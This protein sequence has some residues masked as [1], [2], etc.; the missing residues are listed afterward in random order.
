MLHPTAVTAAAMVQTAHVGGQRAQPGTTRSNP[1]NQALGWDKPLVAPRRQKHRQGAEPK[2]GG[3]RDTAAGTERQTAG[4]HELGR[5]GSRNSPTRRRKCWRTSEVCTHPHTPWLGYPG[6]K[7][8]HNTPSTGDPPRGEQSTWNGQCLL[9]P[10]KCHRVWQHLTMVGQ[11]REL[12]AVMAL[13]EAVF[14]TR[15]KT[16]R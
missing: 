2:A 3:K 9:H 11:G 12:L 5:H 10:S 1:V 6:G 13:G 14:D 8:Q 15:A 7:A 16:N 4:E